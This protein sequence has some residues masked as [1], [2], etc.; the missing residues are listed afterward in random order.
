MPTNKEMGD[1]SAHMIQRIHTLEAENEE[2]RDWMR[3][4]NR[5]AWAHERGCPRAESDAACACGLDAFLSR[6]RAVVESVADLRAEASH[7]RADAEWRHRW[8]SRLGRG[9]GEPEGKFYER[10]EAESSRLRTENERLTA[11]NAELRN[12]CE[13][14]AKLYASLKDL[15]ADEQAGREAAEAESS[16]LRQRVQRV[17]AGLDADAS[18]RA[19]DTF[20]RTEAKYRADQ[21]RA[22]LSPEGAKE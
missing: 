18:Y 6:P 3:A 19:M 22:A 21:L 5:F 15:H 17:I 9:E 1:Q 7:F 13:A 8:H 12:S 2:L 16:R 14:Q 10:M 11:E 20:Y 4:A